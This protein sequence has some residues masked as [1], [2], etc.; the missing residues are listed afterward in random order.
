MAGAQGVQLGFCEG[1]HVQV[2]LLW[3]SLFPQSGGF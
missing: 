1:V 2:K 3:I